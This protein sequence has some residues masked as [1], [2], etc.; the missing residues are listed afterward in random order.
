MKH[1]IHYKPIQKQL[2]INNPNI[3]FE[4]AEYPENSENNINSKI[5]VLYTFH[6]LN[7]RVLYF[8]KNGIF[9]DDNIDYIIIC[10]NTNIDLD[11]LNIPKYVKILYRPNIGY[12]FGAWSYGLL[13][14][15]LYLNYDYFIFLNS[16][17]YGPF[18]K[19]KWTNY[20]INNLTND[21]RL[22]GSTINCS[23]NP[24][25]L[26]HVQSYVFSMNL[27]TLK[28]L[29]NCEIFSLRN[30]SKSFQDCIK[31]KE[32]LMSRK[33]LENGWNISS[34]YPKY[35]KNIDF[36]F[37]NKSPSDYNVVFVNDIITKD[38]YYKNW[39]NETI[40]FVKGNRGFVPRI[41]I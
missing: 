14:N 7:D 18:S 9:Y 19:N 33:I 31:N 25:E 2:H 26:A 41:N 39:N 29:I 8:L 35:Y 36:K 20:Y 32:I 24:R 15:D 17:V 5:L 3:K 38:E 37:K 28:Y 13:Y 6:V 11:I 4:I 21:I 16:S 30:L 10:N 23:E 22:F 27:E 34:L 1:I 12:D 40:I